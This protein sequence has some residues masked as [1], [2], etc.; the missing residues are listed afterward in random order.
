MKMHPEL[1]SNDNFYLNI[2]N[3][4]DSM[5]HTDYLDKKGV[6]DLMEKGKNNHIKTLEFLENKIINNEDIDF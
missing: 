6:K 1:K 3:E 4:I 5:F 2:E